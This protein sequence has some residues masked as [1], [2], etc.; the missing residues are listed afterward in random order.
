MAKNK[1]KKVLIVEDDV[2]LS[3]IYNK[4]FSNEGFEVF[5]A[6]DGKKAV[7]II[8]QKKPDIILLDIM[9]PQMDGFEV[10][11]EI[12]QDP[13]VKDI[14]VILLTNINE[15]D[16]I[17]KG[18]DLGAKDYIIKTFFTPSEVVGKVKKFL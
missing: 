11:E 10:L 2:F 8:K 18:Y 15:Q 17:K 5:T 1:I 16:G 4:K 12:K 3:N 7:I 9:I 14:P 6:S 13:E